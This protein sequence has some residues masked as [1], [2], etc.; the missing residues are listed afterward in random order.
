MNSS[1]DRMTRF[2][3]VDDFESMRKLI[4]KNL[5]SMGY[6]NVFQA[7]NG[8]EALRSLEQNPSIKVLITDWNMPVMSG[9]E[10]LRAVR[11]HDKFKDLPVLM[12]TAEIARHEVQEAAEAG[13]SD[14]LV[15][16]FT[17][18]GLQAKLNRIMDNL[19][20]GVVAG[21]KQQLP[22]GLLGIAKKV[23][24][25]PAA[26]SRPAAAP[27]RPAAAPSRPLA[28]QPTVRDEP[29]ALI[30]TEDLQARMTKQASILVV[31][32]VPANIDVLAGFLQ[33]EYKVRAATSG[34][35][36]L[37]LM[38][39]G[40]LPDLIL[41]DVMMPE[42]DG[43]EVCRRLKANPRTAGIPV[44]FL[45]A[46]DDVTNVVQ[47]FELGAVDYVSK[48]ADPAV[49]ST[50]VRN[51][52]TRSKAFAELQKQNQV[53]AENIRLREDVERM[54]AHD[55]KNPIGGIINFTEML[56]SD[57][58]LTDERK[59]VLQ[60]IDESAHGLLNMVNLSLDLF[61]IEQG[62]YELQ[63]T[64]VDLIPVIRRVLSDINPEVADKQLTVTNTLRGNGVRQEDTPIFH[65]EGDE[66]LCYSLF[67]NLIKNAVEASPP[68]GRLAIVYTRGEDGLGTVA[69]TNTGAVPQSVRAGFFDKYVTA[70]KKGG[71][72]IGTYS[73]Q[74]LAKVQRG[75]I[76]MT[77][78][79]AKNETTVTVILPLTA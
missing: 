61:K 64:Q 18:G 44:I 65:I 39:G 78:D 5:N 10:L 71:T 30:I 79:D 19:Q 74:L 3:V 68:N 32:D 14:F 46:A 58:N 13:V 7:S 67:G 4:I 41:L 72:G 70:G 60:A 55:L 77:A 25:T 53:M 40:K 9:I 73:A 54:T 16:P 75:G 42:M 20:R 38:A 8:R 2:L 69:L 57:E 51:H 48:P 21:L 62:N 12:I 52:L 17:V 28:R 36:A 11:A 33:E 66:L 15:K 49:L 56:L 27:P 1:L 22:E 24:A 50:R 47:G 29:L 59:E 23:T 45:S 26:P 35:M 63:P 31:D 43:F 34:A 76:N 6:T 37:K